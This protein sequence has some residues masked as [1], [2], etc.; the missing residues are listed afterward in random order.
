MERDGIKSGSTHR[1]GCLTSWWHARTAVGVCVN[2]SDVDRGLIPQR[3]PL[4][5]MEELTEQTA[6]SSHFQ[7][8]SR[9]RLSAAAARGGVLL[10]PRIR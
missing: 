7:I 3:Y 4:P 9:L 5:T 1:S 10:R 6:G 8:G 2:L